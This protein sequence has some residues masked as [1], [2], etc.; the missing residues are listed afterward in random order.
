MY[1]TDV[2]RAFYAQVHESTTGNAG[3]FLDETFA[4]DALRFKYTA[5]FLSAVNSSINFILYCLYLPTFRRYW[6]KLFNLR[7][8]ALICEKEQRTLPT[9]FPLEEV[10]RLHAYR[11]SD[12][13]MED[14]QSVQVWHD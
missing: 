5:Y 6:G 9:I 10:P 14:S 13:A 11:Q 4:T 12:D 1:I 2:M 8:F 3:M 7:A